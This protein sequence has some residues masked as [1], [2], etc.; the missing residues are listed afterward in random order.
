MMLGLEEIEAPPERVARP[1]SVFN[2]N[3]TFDTILGASETLKK[4]RK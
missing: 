3:M 2:P 1:V 4:G